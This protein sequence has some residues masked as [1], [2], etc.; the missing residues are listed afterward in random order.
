[1]KLRWAGVE[2]GGP[3]GS[4][5]WVYWWNLLPPHLRYWGFSHDWYDGP[6]GTFGWWFGNVSWQ[7]PW[8]WAHRDP[9]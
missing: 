7:T 5:Y 1:M 2:W 4:W 8:G 6:I 9:D 3:E